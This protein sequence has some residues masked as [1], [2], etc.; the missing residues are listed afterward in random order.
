[1]KLTTLLIKTKGILIFSILVAT[2]TACKKTSC[3]GD[4]FIFGV[5]YSECTGDCARYYMLK[6]GHLYTDNMTRPSE[7]LKFENTSQPSQSYNISKQLLDNLPPV[8]K[9]LPSS[10]LGCPD[11]HDQGMYYIEFSKNSIRRRFKIDT[12]TSKLPHK[13]RPFISRLRVTLDSL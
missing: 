3:T 10:T 6:D 9:T 5:T 12:D 11:C 4:Y 7:K 2:L 8:F 13:L 1:M